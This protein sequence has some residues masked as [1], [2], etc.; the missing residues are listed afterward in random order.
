MRSS[1]PAGHRTFRVLAADSSKRS[2]RELNEGKV[3]CRKLRDTADM[4]DML[5]D[6]WVENI[7]AVAV[8]R[9]AFKTT[10]L[11]RIS[12]PTRRKWRGARTIVASA[13]A[14]ST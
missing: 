7:L 2:H 13:M 8:P 6:A 5:V 1:G 10:S 11:G 3:V 12:P 9:S 14:S 4:G